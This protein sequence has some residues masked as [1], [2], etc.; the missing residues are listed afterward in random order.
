MLSQQQTKHEAKPLQQENARKPNYKESMK[1]NSMPQGPGDDWVLAASRV[2]K[3]D[4]NN[5]LFSE[6]R[7]RTCKVRG[8]LTHRIIILDENG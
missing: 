3:T 7:A 2:L 6:I 8:L 1:I 4:N 5:V